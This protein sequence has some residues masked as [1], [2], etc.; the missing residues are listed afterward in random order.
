MCAVELLCDD[1]HVTL[2]MYVSEPQF[3]VMRVII[4]GP[5]NKIVVVTRKNKSIR[6]Q[7]KNLNICLYTSWNI[8]DQ[9]KTNLGLYGRCC[10]E[11]IGPGT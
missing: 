8:T 10:V 2:K 6:T 1:D 7:N 4:A 11:K 3:N 5:T 9:Y